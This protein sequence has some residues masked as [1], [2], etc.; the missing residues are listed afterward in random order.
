VCVNLSPVQF[1]RGGLA[2][3]VEKVLRAYR[4]KPRRLELEITEGV[5][6]KDSEQTLQ[7]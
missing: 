6:I 4:L 3:L 7:T 2:D 1:T 5:L